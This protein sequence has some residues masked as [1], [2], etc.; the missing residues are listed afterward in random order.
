MNKKQ[1][2]VFLTCFGQLEDPRINRHKKHRPLDIVAI[3]PK[4]H[5]AWHEQARLG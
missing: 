5:N 1:D 4:A 3:T 2:G